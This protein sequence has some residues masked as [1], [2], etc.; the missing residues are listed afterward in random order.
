M[1][2]FFT[3]LSNSRWNVLCLIRWV[4]QDGT[5]LYITVLL[6]AW[7]NT[8]PLIPGQIIAPVKWTRVNCASCPAGTYTVTNGGSVCIFCAASKYTSELAAF[9]QTVCLD[10]SAGSIFAGGAN[11]NIVCPA[12]IYSTRPVEVCSSCS[13]GFYSQG[14]VITCLGCSVCSIREYVV[15]NCSAPVN[16]VCMD[17]TD[18]MVSSHYRRFFTVVGCS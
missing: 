3:E 14:N 15:S 2:N 5:W 10:C 4:L 1:F 7:T 12:G 17:C 13:V 16:I 6:P 18:T 11:V 8:L 9:S